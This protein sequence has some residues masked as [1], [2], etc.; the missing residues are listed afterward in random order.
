MPLRRTVLTASRQLALRCEEALQA[1][2]R[3]ARTGWAAGR[4]ARREF[5]AGD[6]RGTACH[7][8]PDMPL[9]FVHSEGLREACDFVVDFGT[10]VRSAHRPEVPPRRLAGAI[11]E[12]PAGATVHVKT[13]LLDEF[14]THLLPALRRPI[15]LVTGDSD[16]G[17]VA[18]HRALLDDSRVAHWFA[19]NCD[20]PGGHPRLTPI[21]IGLDNPVYTKFEKRLGFALTMAL[22]RTPL[23]LGVKRNDM[24][25]Q[26]ELQR[27]RASLPPPATR[28]LRAL[29]TFHQ[30]QKLIAPSLAGLP[31]RLQAQHDLAGRECCHF[32]PRRLAQR[33]CWRLHGEFAFEIS[34]HGNGLDCFR[35]WEALLL[36]TIPIVRRSALEPLFRGEEL[37][38]VIVD[39]WTE[40]TPANLARWRAELLPRLGPA[41]DT[42]LGLA[43]WVA[44][45]RRA[46]QAAAGAG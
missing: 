34:P 30:N 38:V 40:V 29:C 8:A 22:G 16:A 6:F 46:A 3:L 14:T 36:G 17:W 11:G 9:H 20:L 42:R 25:D 10:N 26:A 1:G 28:P 44:K 24:G 43:H 19:Q 13:D 37:P 39:A 4:Y 41:V 12:L 5:S 15:V 32:V 33:E 18:R 7:C 45:I 31:D 2:V 27:V 23:D 35:T 21:P